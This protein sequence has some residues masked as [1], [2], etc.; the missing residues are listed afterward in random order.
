MTTTDTTVNNLIINT[1]TQAQYNQIT[2][3]NNELYLV[4]DSTITSSE[5]TSALGY[6]PTSPANV[7]G[8]W[9]V[10]HQELAINVSVTKTSTFEYGLTTN[11]G[12]TTSNFDYLPSD[13][14]IYNYDVL[15]CGE[16]K[17]ASTSGDFCAI[18]LQ[19]SVISS[20]DS[21]ISVGICGTQTR[22]SSTTIAL[23]NAIIPVGTDGKL[24]YVTGSTNNS[25][26]GTITIWLVGYRR[27][28][29]NS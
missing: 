9:V 13:S 28:G 8:Q 15:V 22:S 25:F 5:V 16:T 20:S 27:I 24:T 19:S 17:T 21:S 10:K 23:G 7:D 14:N 12:A 1:M 18:K 29:T 2:P 4:T 6:T 11:A 3:S 26:K